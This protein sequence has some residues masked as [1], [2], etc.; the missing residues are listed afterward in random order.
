M[1]RTVHI[2]EFSSNA[3][4]ERPE[5]E[6]YEDLSWTSDVSWRGRALSSAFG[7]NRRGPS[8]GGNTHWS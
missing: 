2:E 4:M 6:P 7:R 3:W 5:E 1:T 8:G